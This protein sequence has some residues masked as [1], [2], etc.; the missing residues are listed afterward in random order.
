MASASAGPLM[1]HAAA[2]LAVAR[3]TKQRDFSR[4]RSMDR[5]SSEPRKQHGRVISAITP[6]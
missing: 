3:F 2:R 5:F 6:H 4:E 1:I